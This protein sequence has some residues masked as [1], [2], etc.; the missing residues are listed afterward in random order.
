MLLPYVVAAIIAI[1]VTTCKADAC[2]EL[3]KFVCNTCL[4]CTWERQSKK[5]V[6]HSQI[7]GFQ[8]S[9]LSLLS[10]PPSWNAV[11]KTKQIWWHYTGQKWI[12]RWRFCHGED[13][14]FLSTLIFS[15]S[16]PN[17]NLFK[18]ICQESYINSFSAL[19]CLKFAVFTNYNT[20]NWV[21]MGQLI[22]WCKS[23]TAYKVQQEQNAH[24]HVPTNVHFPAL[25]FKRLKHPQ[26]VCS[27]F[28]ECCRQVEAGVVSNSSNKF[29]QTTCKPLKGRA[30]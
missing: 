13:E 6:W 28:W 24:D 18:D 23:R 7:L 9:N 5:M 2:A 20:E 12:S 27:W 4:S 3:W 21:F 29:H 8:T 10:L 22:C 11:S 25:M 30:Q 1:I 16:F 15:S 14:Y 17:H 26:M 19:L